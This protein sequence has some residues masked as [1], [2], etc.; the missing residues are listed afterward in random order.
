VTNLEQK[1]PAIIRNEFFY[2]FARL[3]MVGA[4][5]VGLPV[6]A[7]MLNRVVTTADD[8]RAQVQAQNVALTVLANEV[9]FR[10]A[11]VEDHEHRIRRLELGAR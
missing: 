11:T 5:L 9:R 7:W 10:F 8:I 6:A 4:T 2:A 3:C 1:V